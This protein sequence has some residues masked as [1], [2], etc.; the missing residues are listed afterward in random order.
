MATDNEVRQNYSYDDLLKINICIL[1]EKNKEKTLRKKTHAKL[2]RAELE[3]DM[4]RD[5]KAIIEND[6]VKSQ[7]TIENL[8]SHIHT[9]ENE[10]KVYMDENIKI[11]KE[12][13]DIQSS[14]DS[15]IDQVSILQSKLDNLS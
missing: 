13:Y 1:E 9:L 5:E 6:L 11:S 2:S 14:L 7:E 12:K 8:N 10:L 4:L 3:I 15:S